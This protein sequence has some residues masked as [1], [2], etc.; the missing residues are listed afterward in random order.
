MESSE[1]TAVAEARQAGI[2]VPASAPPDVLIGA[3]GD[4][5]ALGV[6]VF[7][8]GALTLGMLFVGVFP[9]AAVGVAVP[10]TIFTSG[11]PLILTTV[12]GFIRGQSVL[13]GI[14][15]TVAGLFTT[16]GFLVIGLDHNWYAIP[17][18]DVPAAQAV[19]FIAFACYFLFLIVPSL[20]LPRLF[21]I[22]IVLVF[23]GLALAAAAQL[24]ARPVLAQIAGAD[25]LVI[26]FVLFWLFLNVHTTAVGVK[27]WPPLGKPL[28]TPVS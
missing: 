5:L 9:A 14:F 16:F 22:A 23:V 28:G 27:P 15:G 10:V 7:A 2:P 18:A 1:I 19:Y 21:T 6:S 26:A 24:A 12:W 4:P 8:I 25:F 13:A 3:G 11:I 20:Q 17:A